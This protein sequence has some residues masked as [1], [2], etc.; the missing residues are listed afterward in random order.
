MSDS[1][2]RG[3]P[4]RLTVALVLIGIVALFPWFSVMIRQVCRG[5]SIGG[6]PVLAAGSFCPED[7]LGKKIDPSK[8]PAGTNTAN[9][10]TGTEMDVYL[11]LIGAD[12]YLLSCADPKDIDGVHCGYE[13]PKK[14]WPGRE[15]VIDDNNR[16]IIQPYRTAPDNR[17]IL[18]SGIWATPELATRLHEEPPR[19]IRK[20][21]LARF[22]ARCRVKFVGG[23]EKPELRWSPTGK[24][25][26]PGAADYY[27]G[28]KE[29][30]VARAISCNII[31]GGKRPEG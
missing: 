19:A 6:W 18:M 26:A 17:L 7:S 22:V 12:S 4:W 20:E 28:R 23:L 10:K 14:R 27:D 1:A 21:K 8:L 2:K 25:A 5:I 13:A 29:I 15:S 16:D 30:P 24:F 3:F 31:E 9:W 11:T